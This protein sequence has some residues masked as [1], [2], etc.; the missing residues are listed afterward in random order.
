MSILAASITTQ[1]VLYGR[2]LVS[3]VRENKSPA[4]KNRSV[5]KKGKALALECE[6]EMLLFLQTMLNFLQKNDF[7]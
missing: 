6:I 7:W 1:V 4:F 2:T 5:H 3:D